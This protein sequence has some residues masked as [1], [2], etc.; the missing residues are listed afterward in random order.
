MDFDDKRIR[1][2]DL[3]YPELSFKIAGILF[4]VFKEVGYGHLEKYYQ[5]FVS[6]SL[7][8]AGLRFK[9]QVFVPMIFGGEKVGRFFL[10]FLIEDEII[11]E[12]KKGD[13]FRKQ[14]IEQILSYLKANNLKL[15]ILAN[16]TSQGVK[17]KRVINL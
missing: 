1:R 17:I 7:K 10:D 5:K 14:N 6:I 3:L 13:Y 2:N 12:I 4:D 8:K 11:L 16:F 9:E 15:G